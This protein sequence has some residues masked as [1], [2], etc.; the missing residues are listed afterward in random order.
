MGG[1]TKYD[2]YNSLSGE[3]H[4]VVHSVFNNILPEDGPVEPKHVA[5]FLYRC[6]CFRQI[7]TFKLILVN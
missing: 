1:N 5:T 6:I 4:G 3:A 7:E 2:N